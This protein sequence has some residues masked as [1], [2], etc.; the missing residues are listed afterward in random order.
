M[1]HNFKAFPELT[2][3]QMA[4][5]YFES[6]HKQIFEDFEAEVVDVIDGDTIK[7]RWRERDFDFRLRLSYINAPEMKEPKGQESKDW[8]TSR[9]N[10]K[11]VQIKINPNNRVEKWG[12][13][14]GRVE[15]GGMDV[16]LESVMLGKAALFGE[17][18]DPLKEGEIKEWP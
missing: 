2:N 8:L 3:E 11:I 1:A 4:V 18:Q 14:L 15:Q 6:P 9:I 5:Y 13:L 7:L 10:G 12:R 17:S 16:G